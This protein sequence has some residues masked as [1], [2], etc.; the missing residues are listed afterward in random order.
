MNGEQPQST[1]NS[2]AGEPQ[3]SQ[4]P[5]SIEERVANMV[6]P[7][8]VLGPAVDKPAAQPAADETQAQGEEQ[9]AEGGEQQA[10]EGEQARPAL[11]DVEFEGKAYKVPPEVKDALMRQADY[12][13]KSQEV[14]ATRRV[15]TQQQQALQAQAAFQQ[16]V[17]EEIGQMKAVEAEIARFNKLDWS[18]LGT[19]E[20]VRTKHALDQLKEAKA[21]IEGS[22]RKKATEFDQQRQQMLAQQIR[23]GQE[24]LRVKI[25]GYSP[26]IAQGI[27][28]YALGEGYTDA[29]VNSL[30][31]P[32]IVVTLWKAQ[33][34][35]SLQA[36]KKN[37]GR[38]VEKAA[39]FVK[40][41]PSSKQQ[42][43]RG[44]LQAKMKA[45]KTPEERLAIGR[46]IMALKMGARF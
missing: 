36:S 4:A 46:Q 15:L 1:V 9:Q 14:A 17:A 5:V 31:D 23:E 41:G 16:T 43:Q 25:A 27:A 44:Q 24:I 12:T 10:V 11:E 2:Q 28:K 21:G 18:S 37:M 42:D 39:P 38:K 20:L 19:D 35:D 8:G 34:W 3:A 45:A 6:K 22:I 7:G 40:P 32:R 29:E 33:Q 30:A 26:T 13:Q